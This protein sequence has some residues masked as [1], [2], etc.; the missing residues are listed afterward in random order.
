MVY[1]NISD[2][3]GLFDGKSL[4]D[5]WIMPISRYSADMT[6]LSS[7]GNAV[8][9]RESGNPKG[10][11]VNKAFSRVSP[12]RAWDDLICYEIFNDHTSI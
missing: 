8:L 6:V 12:S 3:S 5:T 4:W 7:G 1:H 9:Q 10:F 2:R 11:P